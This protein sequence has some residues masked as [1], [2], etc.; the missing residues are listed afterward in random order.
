MDKP[1]ASQHP[2]FPEEELPPSIEDEAAAWFLRRRRGRLSLEET[3]ALQS[4]LLASPA[5]A[6]AWRDTEKTWNCLDEQAVAPELIVARRQALTAMRQAQLRRWAAPS[7]LV[8]RMHTA[9]KSSRTRNWSAA[10]AAIVIAAVGVSFF[11]AAKNGDRYQTGV[12]E[13][14]TVLLPDNSRVTLDAMTQVRVRYGGSARDIELIEGQAQFEVAQQ[15]RRPFRV[16]AG[17]R[18]VEALGTV[19]TVEYIDRQ[20]KVALLEGRVRVD[21]APEFLTQV[22]E[23]SSRDSASG[24]AAVAPIPAEVE[25]KPGETVH[26]DRND[27]QS[28]DTH[29]DL[30]AE[31]AWREGK[32]IFRQE[33][34]GDAVK[35]LNRYSHVQIKVIDSTIESLPVS[36]IFGDTDAEAFA[37]AVAE[38]F[39]VEFQRTGSGAIELQ[40]RR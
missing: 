24:T 40:R 26:F 28:L 8:K 25:L 30:A 27:R 22:A 4:W 17:H 39:P 5:H 10:A 38:Y 2:E 16:R 12:G 14:R 7:S 36:G 21:R 29:V 15:P 19:F 6:A 1:I 9:M 35:R 3:Q 32:V 23:K 18:V 33:P 13:R 31:T 20:M 34:L 37:E 11:W